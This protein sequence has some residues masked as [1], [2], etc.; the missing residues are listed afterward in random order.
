MV[1]AVASP[2]YPSEEDGTDVWGLLVEHLGV[3]IA[4]LT[5]CG[6]CFKHPAFKEES[7]WRLVILRSRDPTRRPNDP[8]PLVRATPTGLLPYVTRSLQP[9]AIAKVVVGPGSQPTLA[10]DA[11]VQLSSNAGYENARDIVVHSAIP[12]RV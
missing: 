8:P 7:E 4:S 1:E 6:F 11:A 5:E 9:D 10:A 2:D 3:V 12:L